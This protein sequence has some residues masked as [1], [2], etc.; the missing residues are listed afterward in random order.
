MPMHR[1]DD[2]SLRLGTFYPSSTS[3]HV[4]SRAIARRNP[5]PFDLR[6]QAR[7]SAACEEAGLD[8]IFLADRWAPYGERC[9]AAMFQDP[10]W[11]APM[12]AAALATTTRHIGLVSTI[13]TTYH[14][15]E[16]VANYGAILDR[17]SGGRWG[18]NIVT[19]FSPNETGLFGLDD[20]GHDDRYA[21]AE[22]FI[23]T[24][25]H[26][27]AGNSGPYRGPYYALDI[28]ATSLAPIQERPL[29][30]NAGASPAGLIF[31]AKHAD[32]IFLTGADGAE[33]KAKIAKVNETAREHGREQG[34]IRAMLHANIVVRDSDD[35]ALALGESIRRQVD[36]DAAR[37]FTAELMG[38]METY[39]RVLGAHG[40]HDRLVRAGSR[41]GGQLLHGSP[42]TVVAEILRLREEYGCRGLAFSFPLW[43]PDEVRA[44]M[45]KILPL[46][47]EAG[48]WVSPYRR[49]WSW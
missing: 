36:L 35:E 7:L 3:I 27:W 33:I 24:M 34:S 38:G 22:D 10:F 49:G 31:A 4:V 6:V 32:W 9:T 26:L 19:G 1:T 23:D 48:V 41:G 37:E 15:P 12:L 30:I 5:D 43:S 46:L 20:I 21:M 14:R 2:T 40:E 29:L 17:L 28:G 44:T 39:R 45:L 13:H 18:F 16:Q 47:A 8:Y 25:K 11:Y 42:R